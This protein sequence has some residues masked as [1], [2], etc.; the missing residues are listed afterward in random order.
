MPSIHQVNHPGRELEIKYRSRIKNIDNYYFLGESHSLG[1]RLWNRCEINGKQN[2]HK[3]KFI[4]HRGKYVKDLSDT[5]E[6]E[7]SLRFWG[8]YEGHSEFELTNLPKQEKYWEAPTAIHKPF[9]CDEKMND[10]NTDPFIF[11]DAFYYAV[12]KKTKLKD[13]GL[14]DIVL[15]GSEFGRKGSDKF[16]LD[17]LFVVDKVQDSILDGDIYDRIYIESTLRRL[18]VTE[19]Q[20]GEMPIH[21]GK[22]FTSIQNDT[23][24]FFPAVTE[25][26]KRFDRPVIDT[27]KYNLQKPGARTGAKSRRLKDNESVNIIWREIANDVID[28]GFVLG[29]HA[30]KL[31]ILKCLP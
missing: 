7:A 4:E 3:R 24:S 27:E 5:T 16:Y 28:Q 21:V 2:S 6:K 26:S 10:Q 11:G 1:I 22:K 18:G 12:C 15:F 8:E 29:T 25:E 9:F 30:N 14:G 23:F 20:K 19:K 31:P 17:T 13:I